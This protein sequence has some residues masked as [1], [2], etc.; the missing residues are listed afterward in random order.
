MAAGIYSVETWVTLPPGGNVMESPPLS[1]WEVPP[2]I[3]VGFTLCMICPLFC[4]PV[5][6]LYSA[7]IW[8]IGFRRLSRYN[9]LTQPVRVEIY[10]YIQMHPGTPFSVIAE[11]N[12]INRGTLHYHLH[13]LLR[14]GRI[15]EWREGGRTTYFENNGKYSMNEKQILSR[16]RSGTAGEICMF[17]AMCHGATRSEIA[18]RMN[19]APS[20][21][22]WHLSRL[23]SS[24][25]VISEKDGQKTTYCLTSEATTLI[26]RCLP[27]I[28]LWGEYN[29]ENADFSV[30]SS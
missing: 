12:E 18:Q 7:G 29:G 3:R 19:I 2:L 23:N 17:L 25:I 27:E 28:M 13:I 20:S 10:N 6:L 26:Y 22:S 14:E 4:L 9:V 15:L 5:E 16:L 21:V 8:C 30:Y 24:G 11:K 1:W